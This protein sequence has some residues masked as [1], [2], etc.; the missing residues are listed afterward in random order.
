MKQVKLLSA[1]DRVEITEEGA[2]AHQRHHD[3]HV[4]VV[5]KVSPPFTRT[6]AEGV[7]QIVFTFPEPGFKG[8]IVEVRRRWWEQPGYDYLVRWDECSGQSWHL[9]KHLLLIE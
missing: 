9:L 7:K 3:D 5:A 6:A 1:G 8:T 4:D 2:L